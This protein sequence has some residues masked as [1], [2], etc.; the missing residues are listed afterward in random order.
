MLYQLRSSDPVLQGRLLLFHEVVLIKLLA[1]IPR[2]LRPLL[3]LRHVHVILSNF[4]CFESLGLLGIGSLVAVFSVL[5]LNSSL[6]GSLFLPLLLFLSLLVADELL[7]LF[8][9]SLLQLEFLLLASEYSHF[10]VFRDLVQLRLLVIL[11]CAKL[12]LLLLLEGI[13]PIP[14]LFGLAIHDISLI[15]FHIYF[16]EIN[17]CILCTN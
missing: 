2:H 8:L 14:Y 6:N 9:I 11:L 13:I 17:Y 15:R 7:R 12:S 1:N 16:S 5:L 4:H 10:P 3:V